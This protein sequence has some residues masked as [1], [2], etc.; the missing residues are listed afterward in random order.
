MKYLAII[1]LIFLA[2]LFP[3]S[4]HALPKYGVSTL[5]S[6]HKEYN[7]SLFD[8]SGSHDYELKLLRNGR[9]LVKYPFE[10][11]LV[12]AYWSPSLKFVAVNNHYGHGGT[13]VWIIIRRT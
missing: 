6:P 2:D 13:H 11:E 3:T 4:V 8:A 7:I 10:G 9:E 12:S 1:L 5:V